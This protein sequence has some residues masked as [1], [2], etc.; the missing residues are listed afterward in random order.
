MDKE[1]GRRSRQR[2]L[3]EQRQGNRTVEQVWDAGS[4]SGLLKCEVHGMED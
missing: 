3:N 1:E 4:Q 2:A